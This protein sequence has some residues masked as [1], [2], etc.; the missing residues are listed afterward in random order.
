MCG[1][2]GRGECARWLC[3]TAGAGVPSAEH[4]G[5]K[6]LQQKA[7]YLCCSPSPF[8]DP[9]CHRD[10]PRMLLVPSVGEKGGKMRFA[11]LFGCLLW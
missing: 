1:P 10:A 9:L 6:E 3:C 7:Q 2:T 4:P 11:Y 8:P 5:S